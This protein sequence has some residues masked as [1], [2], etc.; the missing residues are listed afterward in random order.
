M[1]SMAHTLMST[2]PRFKPTA[3][4][5]CSSRSDSTPELFF[6]QQTQKLPAGATNLLHLVVALLQRLD[7][8]SKEQHHVVGAAQCSRLG[9]TVRQ[10][11]QGAVEAGG[12]LDD[13]ETGTR[14]DA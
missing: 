7:A 12:R 6:G 8:L 14:V 9:Y 2:Q 5:T 13:A 4:T 3:R 10:L 11:A 1:S